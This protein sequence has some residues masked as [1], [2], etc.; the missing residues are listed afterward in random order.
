MS[1]PHEPNWPGQQYPQRPGQSPHR[2]P[3]PPQYPP[4]YPAPP[5]Q[6]AQYPPQ[7]PAPYGYPQEARKP[8]NTTLLWVG[9]GSVLALVL[10]VAAVVLLL[11]KSRGETAPQP[12]QNT[13]MGPGAASTGS[14]AQPST[15]ASRPNLLDKSAE[16]L[17]PL[18]PTAADFP[19]GTQVLPFIDRA[20]EANS[21]DRAKPLPPE[22]TNPPGCWTHLEIRKNRDD[23]PDITRIVTTQA[24]NAQ[25]KTIAAA[26]ITKENNGVDALEQSKSWLGRCQEFDFVQQLK[27]GQ[28]PIHFKMSPLPEPAGF[29]DPFFGAKFTEL[30]PNGPRA[31]RYF[32]AARVRGLLVLSEG[33]CDLSSCDESQ[34]AQISQQIPI[35]FSKIVQGLRNAQ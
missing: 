26:Q 33:V 27:D 28:P 11:G 6:H 29:S 15:G 17:L 34:N 14:S 2:P 31:Y 5:S 1:S 8:R 30:G 13:A 23:I 20:G 35:M 16:Q 19:Q 10:V 25:G 4:Q 3:Y 18:M 12:P 32:F 9:A 24:K 7:R 21:E 22:A